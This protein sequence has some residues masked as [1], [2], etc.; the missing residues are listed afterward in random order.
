M[1]SSASRVVLFDI[2]TRRSRV[3]VA[4][5]CEV[6]ADVA[7]S[8]RV[9]AAL[10]EGGG[11][12]AAATSTL[13]PFVRHLLLQALQ[14]DVGANAYGVCVNTCGSTALT[15]AYAACLPPAGFTVLNS[16]AC[17]LVCAGYH[18]GLVLD[19]GYTDTRAVPIVEGVVL[20]QCAVFAPL[21]AQMVLDH[22]S[23][24]L[25]RLNRD[26]ADAAC[27]EQLLQQHGRVMERAAAVDVRAAAAGAA[28]AG[29]ATP[30]PPATEQVVLSSGTLRV[31]A[32]A[33]FEALFDG[34][35]PSADSFTLQ[36]VVAACLGKVGVVSRADVAACVV[37]AGGV[38]GARGFARRLAQEMLAA[39]EAGGAEEDRPQQRR[40][41]G[42]ALL[43]RVR[44]ATPGYPPK[45]LAIVGASLMK[46][47][48]CL[49]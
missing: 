15:A 37:L 34:T 26:L 47:T 22:F 39:Y 2:G 44:I 25:A 29:A 24:W 46:S 42:A 17:A 7:T 6:L 20:E 10:T 5:Q 27:A 31:P 28:T 38:C 1:S 40:G 4:G 32:S 35:E 16:Q 45:A 14:C 49:Q 30:T 9:A 33:S 12:G 19:V 3:G 41:G 43:R 23:S 21:S 8:P 13:G 36:G 48:K 18:T 11:S